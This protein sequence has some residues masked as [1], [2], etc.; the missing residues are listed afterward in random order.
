MQVS[1]EV[2]VGARREKKHRKGN[3][4]FLVNNFTQ[5]QTFRT[6]GSAYALYLVLYGISFREP[7]RH[8]REYVQT[9]NFWAFAGGSIGGGC[10]RWAKNGW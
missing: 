6:E 7:N 2:G 1:G 5:A 8:Q 3:K 4:T 10:M 9:R